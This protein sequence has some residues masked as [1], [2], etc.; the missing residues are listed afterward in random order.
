MEAPPVP[1]PVEVR[2]W[3]DGEWRPLA[4]VVS[5]EVPVSVVWEGGS[6]RLW[7]WPQDIGD[8]ALGH[9]L[10]D[11]LHDGPPDGPSPAGIRRGDAR[12]TDGVWHVRL[13]P[14]P[15]PPAVADVA[16][17]AAKG[18]EP[19]RGAASAPGR[20]SAPELLETM[21]MF[22]GAQGLWD[23]TGCFHRAGVFSVTKGEV[24]R[25]AEDIG[26]HNCIDRLA[27]WAAREGVDLSSHVLLVSARVTAS[28]F[29]KA[30]RAGFTWIVSRS[31][32]TTAS[33][34]MAREQGVT[35]VGF[36]RD[37]EER[38]TVFTDRAG[39]VAP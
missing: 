13:A 12:C 7:A 26:R 18:E 22:M 15:A 11:R 21:R 19:Q 9:V 17:D 28:L 20:L 10:L 4:D 37:R 24:V 33:V 3:R 29:A 23:G 36:A 38:F 31:A 30:R 39:R 5:H 32:V 16:P 35:L 8:L 34:D 1:R 25:R 27:G 2:Q 14:T 6:C